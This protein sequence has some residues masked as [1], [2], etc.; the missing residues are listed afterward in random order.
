MENLALF[1]YEV[2]LH[3]LAVGSYIAAAF[4]FVQG[5]VFQKEKSYGYGMKLIIAGLLPHCLALVIRWSYVYH[6]PYL[7]KYEVLSSDAWITLLAF[8]FVFFKYHRLRFTGMF[9]VPFAFLMTVVALFSNNAMK[10]LPSGYKGVWLVAH[11]L[12]TKL[13]V[14]AFLI[15]IALLMVYFLKVRKSNFA[16]LFRLPEVA[17]LDEY[18][19][20]FTAFGFCFWTVT[21]VAGAIWAEQSWGRYWG[22]DPVEIWSLIVWLLLGSYLHLRLFFN[23]RGLK[24]ALFLSLCYFVSLLTVFFLP[25]IINSL[26]AEYFK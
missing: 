18:I 13:A 1:K 12:V 23:W 2:I 14:A 20:K 11:I 9:V 21:I 22:W 5:A 16:F 6:G 15:A 4:F 7:L 25:F 19:Y 26:H 3:W 8:L 17:I 24:G 10:R